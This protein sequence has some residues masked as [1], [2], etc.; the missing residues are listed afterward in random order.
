MMQRGVRRGLLAASIGA[1]G[2]LAWIGAAGAQPP[3]APA[4]PP[5]TPAQPPSF[6]AGAS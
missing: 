3:G 6:R 5:D 2:W 1:A 4:Q